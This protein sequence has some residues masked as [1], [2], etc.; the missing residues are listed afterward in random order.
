MLR[1]GP[2]PN[3]TQSVQL[4]AVVQGAAARAPAA[5]ARNKMIKRFMGNSS[6]SGGTCSA[7]HG[8]FP[9]RRIEAVRGRGLYWS[10]G[11]ARIRAAC[12]VSAALR[13]TCLQGEHAACRAELA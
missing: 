9:A 6:I 1:Q 3:V 2:P 13:P 12:H 8:R 10:R 4:V 11:P 7:R 5:V